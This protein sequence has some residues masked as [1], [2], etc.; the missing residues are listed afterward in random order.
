[1][2]IIVILNLVLTKPAIKS[3]FRDETC[4]F[5]IGKGRFESIFKIRDQT[6]LLALVRKTIRVI[7]YNA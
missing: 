1:M 4:K 2:G 7:Y 6:C 3:S 5:E